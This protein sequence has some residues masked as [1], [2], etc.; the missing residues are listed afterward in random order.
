[1]YSVFKE[2]GLGESGGILH[3]VNFH[4]KKHKNLLQEQTLVVCLK[5][6]GGAVEL[7]EGLSCCI[8]RFLKENF[9]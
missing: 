8:V 7:G 3:K 9:F 1:M 2:V 4:T 6:P 5:L